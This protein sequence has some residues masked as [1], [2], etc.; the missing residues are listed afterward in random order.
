MYSIHRNDEAIESLTPTFLSYEATLIDEIQGFATKQS[1]SSR[2]FSCVAS[3]VVATSPY[4]GLV[5]YEGG[6]R[7]R[8]QPGDE[9]V[10]DIQYCPKAIYYDPVYVLQSTTAL[11]CLPE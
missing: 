4:P 3:P 9:T 8:M 11:I 5:L 10:V 1:S 6:S 2:V 7:S